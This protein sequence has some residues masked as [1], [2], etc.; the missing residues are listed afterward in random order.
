M[1][2]SFKIRDALITFGHQGILTQ[3]LPGANIG[4]AAA[5]RPFLVAESRENRGWWIQL[6][7]V[8]IELTPQHTDEIC[9]VVDRLA[10]CYL[11]AAEDLERY[12]L[13]SIRFPYAQR[14]YRLYRI[15][16]WLWSTVLAFAEAHQYRMGDSEWH[17]FSTNG[18]GFAIFPRDGGHPVALF[19]AEPDHWD[20]GIC[21]DPRPIIRF[22][23]SEHTWDAETAHDWFARLLPH[24]IAWSQGWRGPGTGYPL[25][26]RLVRWLGLTGWK[27]LGSASQLERLDIGTSERQ[28]DLPRTAGM[29]FRSYEALR[30]T[31]YAMQSHYYARSTDTGCVRGTSAAGV[32]EF[33]SWCARTMDLAGTRTAHAHRA[34]GHNSDISFTAAVEQAGLE[35][36]HKAA[37]HPAAMDYALRGV[38]EMLQ[39]PV[40]GNHEDALVDAAVTY[41]AS[42]V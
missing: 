31:V 21:W 35:S 28:T 23:S 18:N 2:K 22:S 38:I 27:G 3:L 41:L 14:G 19:H 34:L 15:P 20:I 24:T 12:V 42:F 33:L 37:V 9:E 1:F 17:V 11:T 16:P 7:N 13:R 10:E 29:A 26:T 4:R 39:E 32:Y 36:R 30:T 8:R 40:V 6:S 25:V 5:E